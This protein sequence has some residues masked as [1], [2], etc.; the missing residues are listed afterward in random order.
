MN[1]ETTKEFA[2]VLI[3]AIVAL[4]IV[5]VIKNIRAETPE[6]GPPPPA[7]SAYEYDTDLDWAW[8]VVQKDKK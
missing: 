5:T 6:F 1:A 8:G 7:P 3:V 2:L 4:A